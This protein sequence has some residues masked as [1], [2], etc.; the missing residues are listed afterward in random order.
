MKKTFF[1]L[2]CIGIC[3]CT[4][5]QMKVYSN[6]VSIGGEKIT[7]KPANLGPEI[8]GSDG[9]RWSTIKFWHS[10]AGWNKLQAK[11]FRTISDSC[12][13]TDVELIEEATPLL[14]QVNTYSYRFKEDESV[15][16]KRSYGI[17]QQLESFHE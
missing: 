16:D 17:I 6:R 7:L 9:S 11:S 8:G 10:N 2:L 12:F 3:I 1:V 5:A 14:Q 13:K 4:E 15:A